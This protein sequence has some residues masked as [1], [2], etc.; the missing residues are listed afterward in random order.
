MIDPGDPPP[1]VGRALADI[2]AACFVAA[3]VME[4]IQ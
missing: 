3:L 4:W 1:S 2:I